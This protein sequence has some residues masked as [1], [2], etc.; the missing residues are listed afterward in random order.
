MEGRFTV[1]DRQPRSFRCRTCCE[2]TG[3]MLQFLTYFNDH[4][5]ECV[6]QCCGVSPA[7]LWCRNVF[8]DS[9][10]V[11]CLW[12]GVS[13]RGL[14]GPSLFGLAHCHSGKIKPGRDGLQHT[15]N[16][17]YYFTWGCSP[18]RKCGNVWNW[19][20]SEEF[21]QFTHVQSANVRTFRKNYVI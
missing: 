15:L 18:G 9:F 19:N 7:M 12:S 21:K 5:T 16:N 13:R 3:P 10:S 6:L 2:F 8:V 1:E 20:S 14:H 11:N 17:K 4:W